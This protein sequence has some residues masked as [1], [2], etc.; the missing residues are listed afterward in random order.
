MQLESIRVAI[1]DDERMVAEAIGY[2]L[3]SFG[4]NVVGLVHSGQGAIDLVELEAPDILILDLLMPG[5]NGFEVVETIR[6]QGLDTRILLLTSSKNPQNVVR[7]VRLGVAAYVSK[8]ISPDNLRDNL[9]SI[10]EGD[11]KLS[12]VDVDRVFSWDSDELDDRDYGLIESLT[13]QEAR[14]LRMIAVGL[15]NEE[16][17]LLLDI[18]VNTVKTHVRHIYQK[19]AVE[20]RTNAVIWAVQ[21]GAYPMQLSAGQS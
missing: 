8:E 10:V 7:A 13:D 3:E 19:L 11:N 14:V 5:K 6:D 4:F 15:N 12:T 1:A 9:V 2:T 16:I 17:A 18:S 20:D 21:Q